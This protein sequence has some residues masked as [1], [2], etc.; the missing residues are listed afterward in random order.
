MN[1]HTRQTSHKQLQSLSEQTLHKALQLYK[2]Q[3]YKQVIELV[4]QMPLKQVTSALYYLIGRSYEKLCQ[5]QQALDCYAKAIALDPHKST[6]H[7]KKAN[8]LKALKRFDTAMLC[9][10]KAITL[11]NDDLEAL[12]N[13]ANLLITQKMHEPALAAFDLVNKYHPKFEQA[14]YNKA[15]LLIQIGR[16]QEAKICTEQGLSIGGAMQESLFRKLL[17]IY[18]ELEDWDE[19]ARVCKR[20]KTVLPH[21]SLCMI[22]TAVRYREIGLHKDALASIDVALRLYPHDTEVLREKVNVLSITG[23]IT[24]EFLCETLKVCEMQVREQPPVLQYH[25]LLLQ[26]FCHQELGHYEPAKCCLKQVSDIANAHNLTAP[27]VQL[28]DLCVCEGEYAEAETLIKKSLAM[29]D[30]SGTQFILGKLGAFKGDWQQAWV[31]LGPLYSR[32]WLNE[33][34]GLYAQQWTGT[35]DLNDKTLLVIRKW[36][37]GDIIQYVRFVLEVKQRYPMVRITAL[38]PEKLLPVLNN[39]PISAVAEFVASDVQ[40]PE[41][42]GQK[43]HLLPHDYYVTSMALPGC[44]KLFD[45]GKFWPGK[46][47]LSF[48]TELRDELRQ[49]YLGNKNKRLIGFSWFGGHEYSRI[50]ERSIAI[51]QWEPLFSRAEVQWLSVQY[52]EH[53]ETLAELN[54]NLGTNVIWDECFNTYHD[55]RSWAA[56]IMA[57]DL[58]ITVDN[59]VAHLAGALGR[60]TW[61]LLPVV[62]EFRWTAQGETTPWYDNMHLFRQ[63]KADAWPEVI[64]RVIAR[65]DQEQ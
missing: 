39:S 62:P 32:V 1:Q 47:Y 9:Y 45:A 4:K 15:S 12:N 21:S 26:S 59:S 24:E 40:N 13:R 57:C 31:G 35:T 52:G 54:K 16:V 36:G 50:R 11:K 33:V 5:Y 17:Q 46:P 2:A 51:E 27:W 20:I 56:Q 53:A 29:S 55:I 34:A 60:E 8:V 7:L 41:C 23:G 10:D 38:M 63:T 65:L 3:R 44:I 14:Y 30:G 18:V 49:R 22:Y 61:L 19:V 58:I 37:I 64:K 48:D 25:T 43:I 6:Y 28:A 42:K